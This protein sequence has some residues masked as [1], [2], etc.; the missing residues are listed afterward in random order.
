MKV[1]I[2]SDGPNITTGYG[3]I[4]KQF[5]KYLLRR[6]GVEIAFGSLQ[7]LGSPLYIKVDS[8]YLTVYSCHG[9]QQPYLEK[10]LIDFRP[11]FLIHIRD[12]IVLSQPHFYGSYRLKPVASQYNCKVIHWAPVMGNL[13]IEIIQALSDDSDLVLCPTEWGFNLLLF[14]GFPSNRMRVL[15]WGIDTEVFYP[16]SGDKGIFGIPNSRMVIG[17]VGVHDRREKNYPLLMKAVSILLKKYDLDLYIHSS[18]GAVSLEQYAEILGLKGR[19]LKPKIYI[20]DWGYPEDLM[21]KIYCSLDCYVSASGAEGFNIPINEALCC[22]TPTVAS[23]HPVH[24]EVAGKLALLAEAK[25]LM[26]D[27][28]HFNYI[29]DPDDLAKKVEKVINGE[30]IIDEQAWKEYVDWIRWESQVNRF[31]EIIN[32]MFGMR[33]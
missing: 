32:E 18:S 33:I 3:N 17:T 12:P 28:F 26:P 16:D 2:I 22:M 7:Q 9:G 30:Y 29:V 23:A 25:P 15:R 8:E 6:G 31:A 13:P 24:V 11:D 4:A 27:L 1:L 14:G 5:A 21:R 10:A 20:K 19:V